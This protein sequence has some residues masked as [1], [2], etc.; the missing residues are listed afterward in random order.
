MTTPNLENLLEPILKRDS[1]YPAEAYCFVRDALDHTVRQFGKPR[2]ISGQELLSGI[3]EYALAEYGPVTKR[4]LQEWGINECIDFG[5]LVF[6]L[7]NEGLLGKTDGDSLDDF[8]DGYDFAEAF[9]HPFQP[10]KP[11]SCSLNTVATAP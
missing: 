3:R 4:V 5:H 2:H 6:N 8:A 1:R 10:K 11:K 7:V 9:E